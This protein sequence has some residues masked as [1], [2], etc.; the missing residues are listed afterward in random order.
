[1]ALIS[2]QNISIAFG[3][4][5][6][7]E[8]L[9]F[10]IA[11]KQRIC[12]LGRN[13]TGKSTL[14]KIIDSSIPT[15]TGTI[16]KD[17]KIKISYF[18]QKISQNLS[19]SVFEII[20]K[21]LGIRG[22]LLVKIHHEEK[23]ISEHTDND[24]S[25]LNKLHEEMDHFNAW[26]AQ[27]QID[28]II[29]RMDL[30]SDWEYQSLS[31]GQKRRV[32]LAASLVSEPDLLLLDEP[33]NHLDIR[34][35]AWMEEFLLNLN[36]TLL[37]VTHDRMLLRKLATRIIE[38]DRGQ[39]V[40]WACDYDTFLERKQAVLDIQEK[41]WEKFDKK[42][43]Q[44]EVWIR[45][46][47]KARRTR[48]EGRVRALKKMRE[49]RAKRRTREGSVSLNLA[50]GQRSGK[51]VIEAKNVCFG[52]DETPLIND[53]NT[54][55]ARGD[56]IGIIG[57]NGC[58]K[59]TLIKILLGELAP[60]SGSIKLGT[61]LSIAYFDQ[62]RETLDEEKTIWENVLPHGQ[63]V[64]IEGHKKHIISYLQ[65]FLFTPERAKT[66]V[67]SLSGGERNRLLLARLFT[68]PS[69]FLILDEPTNDL[70][71]ETLELLEELL[72]NFKGTVLLI[73]HDRAFLNNVV[74]NTFSFSEDGFIN[75]TVGGYDE[76]LKKTNEQL[77][78]PK[79]EEKVDKKKQYK[80]TQ[81]AKRTKKLSFKEQKELEA[82]PAQIE[83]FE[84]EQNALYEKMADPAFYQN[85]EDVVDA[86]KRIEELGAELPKIYERWEFLE[87]Y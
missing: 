11:R 19:G 77:P 73:C 28:E 25:T 6:I 67:K 87:S 64:E 8:D 21:G 16:F 38:L 12:L 82:L 53:F 17:Q 23:R 47:I 33:T 61:N 72:V 35:I 66:P 46:G 55:I 80:D 49:E 30:N 48:S 9:S 57:P 68:Q 42:L 5:K 1:M 54:L 63:F 39:L 27:N 76:W 83:L 40:D 62:M 56:K 86:K 78:L 85:K 4:Q 29:S 65:D 24:H 7:L 26:S 20:A 37:F 22:E 2:L 60:N 50:D 31:G 45:K 74:T 59:T 84:K 34:T 71:T 41:E 52:Y 58:G 13:G 36:A 51:L 18:A 75:E 44:E 14:M 3:G 43:A 79:Y 70:D 69:N 15:D 10:Q 32:L 81:K